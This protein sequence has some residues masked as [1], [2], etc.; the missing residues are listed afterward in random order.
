[1]TDI[2]P[3]DL[4]DVILKPGVMSDTAISMILNPEHPNDPG[5]FWL[6]N[7]APLTCHL[8]E[9]AL[10]SPWYVISAVC[11]LRNISFAW[12]KH[13]NACR[14]ERNSYIRLKNHQMS[15]AY[16]QSKLKRASFLT[17]K[18]L[19]LNHIYIHYPQYS[20]MKEKLSKSW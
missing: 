4:K 8:L 18:F 20:S 5:G 10:C 1:M 12:S 17:I 11:S 9:N 13:L 6:V 7:K 2:N 15:C 3:N 19:A 14:I 16:L